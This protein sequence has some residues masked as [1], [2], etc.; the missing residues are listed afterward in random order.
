[1][2][3][4][5]DGRQPPVLGAV[6]VDLENLHISIRQ[7]FGEA[8]DRT[9]RILQALRKHL[10]EDLGISVVVGRAYAPLDYSTSRDL[11]NDLSLLGITPVHVLASPTKNSADLML[12][13][14]CMEFLFRRSDIEV[15]VIVGGDRDYIPVV[16]RIRQNARSVLVVGPR[17]ATSGDLVTIV[18]QKNYIDAVSLLP[19]SL[20]VPAAWETPPVRQALVE[21]P[22]VEAPETP[23]APMP[24]SEP[25]PEPESEPEP[26]PRPALETMADV[27]L[28]VADPVELE[29]LKACL[30]V[31]VRI[32]SRLGVAEVW[33]GPLY[34]HLNEALPAKNNLQRKDLISRL[35]NL[36]AIEIAS[37][38]RMDEGRVSGTY[39]VVTVNWKHPLVL[40]AN[41]D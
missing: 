26:E 20:R 2:T 18:G 8:M 32:Q 21:P 3:A 25:E 5:R 9:I 4:N 39:S 19:P 29:D 30:A 7:E 41:P 27:E 22:K 33:L 24:E 15:F 10:E 40:E 14:D 38:P 11:I 1:M 28:I 31:I 36:G 17:Y 23:L 13:I 35:A 37:R 12:A 16:D 34:R 6:F